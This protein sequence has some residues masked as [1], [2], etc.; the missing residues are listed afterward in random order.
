MSTLGPKFLIRCH[1][2]AKWNRALALDPSSSTEVFVEDSQG[3]GWKAEVYSDSFKKNLLETALPLDAYVAHIIRE[4]AELIYLF[5][6]QAQ[7]EIF[8]NLNAIKG[9]NVNVAA[10][11]TAIVGPALL[12]QWVQGASTKGYKFSGLG[13]KSIEKL[14]YEMQAKKAKFVPMLQAAM[15]D[16]P[17]TLA[18]QGATHA[19]V[20]PTILLGLEKLGLR[21]SDTLRIIENLKLNDAKVTSLSDQELIAKILQF[22]GKEKWSQKS[23][24]QSE[25]ES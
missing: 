25:A 9:I 10:T 16:A 21:P 8:E 17:A 23:S 5:E 24:K 12:L 18:S 6:T 11:A 4:D 20:A 3:N 19:M 14:V 7:R 13:P 2:P 22:W 15:S 1:A